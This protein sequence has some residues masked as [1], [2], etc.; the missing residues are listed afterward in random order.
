MPA[1]ASGK[2]SFN[3]FSGSVRSDLPI[4]MGSRTKRRDFSADL[5]NGNGPTLRFTTFSG[6]LR[7]EK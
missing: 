1:S 7:I 3:S 5:G 2:I 4:D 6:D